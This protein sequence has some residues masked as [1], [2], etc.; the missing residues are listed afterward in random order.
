M[1]QGEAQITRTLK[2]TTWRRF[3]AKI[4]EVE[5]RTER[6]KGAGTGADAAKPPKLDRTISWEVFR[7]QFETVAEHS[8]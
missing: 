2:D 8:C 7:H 4:A 1:I 5:A 6:G 3:D